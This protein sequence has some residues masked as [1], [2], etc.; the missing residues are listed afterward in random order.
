MSVNLVVVKRLGI[1]GM[2]FS[3]SVGEKCDVVLFVG[4]EFV[5]ELG[6]HLFMRWYVSL[7]VWRGR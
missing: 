4:I 5:T 7:F 1:M 3:V 6:F 2:I